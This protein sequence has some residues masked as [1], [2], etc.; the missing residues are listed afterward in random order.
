MIDGRTVLE[1]PVAAGLRT[2]MTIFPPE[3]HGRRRR[4]GAG[5]RRHPRRS[6]RPEETFF[7][8]F[9]P[10]GSRRRRQIWIGSRRPD[11]QFASLNFSRRCQEKA[12]RRVCRGRRSCR[13]AITR[14]SRLSGDGSQRGIA[15]ARRT[16]TTESHA[17]STKTTRRRHFTGKQRWLGRTA[18]E[19]DCCRS[20]SLKK[21]LLWR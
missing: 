10:G 14:R 12:S 21:K 19:S 6:E 16:P 11:S 13:S 15:A 4:G 9:S 5:R 7:P 17:K 18:R 1:S 20:T 8:H 3:S 2:V